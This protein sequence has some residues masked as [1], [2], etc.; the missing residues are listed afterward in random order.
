[1]YNALVV[2]LVSK[3][4]GN[5]FVVDVY[6]SQF[7]YEISIS[8]SHLTKSFIWVLIF[9]FNFVSEKGTFVSIFIS[10]KELK[11]ARLLYCCFAPRSVVISVTSSQDWR[12]RSSCVHSRRTTP[13]HCYDLHQASFQ[14]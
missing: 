9:N 6:G 8:I 12:S 7:K 3:Q 11:Q 10:P 14:T 13:C 4:G 2:R 1:M 5:Q